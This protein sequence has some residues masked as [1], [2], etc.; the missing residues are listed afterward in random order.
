[1][2]DNVSSLEWNTISQPSE[3][4]TRAPTSEANHTF[5]ALNP[6]HKDTSYM[7]GHTAYPKPLNP[8]RKSFPYLHRL[9]LLRPVVSLHDQI[10]VYPLENRSLASTRFLPVFDLPT[11]KSC[12]AVKRINATK[13]SNNLDPEENLLGAKVG[14][15]NNSTG[16]DTSPFVLQLSES[17]LKENSY[18]GVTKLN[19]APECLDIIDLDKFQK[20]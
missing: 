14:A 10:S 12:D 5:H 6:K 4:E 11:I 15:E 17:N 16:M 9:S 13:S 3:L 18:I 1:M 20:F 8:A 2:S 19:N 7:S